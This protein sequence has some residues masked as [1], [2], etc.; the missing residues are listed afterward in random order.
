MPDWTEE[1][2]NTI[3]WS[4]G[5]IMVTRGAMGELS[6]GEIALLIKGDASA[7]VTRADMEN[8]WG[9]KPPTTTWTEE[10][11]GTISWTEEEKGV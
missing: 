6:R 1:T 2:K 4:T 9:T 11:K 3:S 7:T 8:Y 10:N 5:S